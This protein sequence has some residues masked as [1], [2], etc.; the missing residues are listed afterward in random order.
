[1]NKL[2]SLKAHK[3]PD[4]PPLVCLTAYSAPMAACLDQYAD[5][6]LVGDSVGMVL[7]GEPTTETVDLD[8]MIRHGR[9]VKRK[10]QKAIVIV[11]MPTGSYE[12][13]PDTA[14]KNA[15]YVM[16]QTG[17][18]G[19]KLEGGVDLAETVQALVDGG[20]PVIGHVGLMPQRAG[21]KFRV[22]GKKR[23]DKDRIMKDALAIE[24]AGA[25]AVV[26]EAVYEKLAESITNKLGIPT[27]GIGASAKCDG[28]ILVSEDMLGMT[29]GPL[30]RFVKTYCDLNTHISQA[31]N[32]YKNDVRNRI[33][34]DAKHLYRPKKS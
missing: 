17:C 32:Q 18:D 25:S 29:E 30:P 1:M 33:F 26:I 31:V 11:D 24:Q 16:D 14:L 19:V 34:P 3:G 22:Q 7:Y 21:G 2:K 23:E 5:L 4:A 6:L 9:A 13:D 10:A 28:Q 12:S 8:T 20:V 27:I 15:T